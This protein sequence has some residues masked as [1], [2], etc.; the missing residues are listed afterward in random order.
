LAV[1]LARLA[2][3]VV[4]W[5]VVGRRVVAGR[6]FARDVRLVIERMAALRPERER[7]VVFRRARR[8]HVAACVLS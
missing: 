5:L 4:P 8:Q 7:H 3:A 6:D 2:W 1:A